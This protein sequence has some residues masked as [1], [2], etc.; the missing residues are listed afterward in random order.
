[1]STSHLVWARLGSDVGKKIY[2]QLKASLK[3]IH[4]SINEY[5]DNQTTFSPELYLG[6]NIDNTTRLTLENNIG[7]LV[8]NNALRSELEQKISNYEILRGNVD[9]KNYIYY[10][11]VLTLSKNFNII[12]MSASVGSMIYSHSVQDV[13]Y[14][15]GDKLV[16]T[17]K[18]GDRYV[19]SKAEIAM[20]GYL[21]NRSLQIM[22]TLSYLAM[23]TNDDFRKSINNW[24]H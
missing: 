10:N 16:H 1:M 2:A 22:G 6:Y 5:R 13:Y 8:P 21:L 19:Q 12:N 7:Y 24:T 4:T 15:E 3:F 23:N 18:K 17:F 14:G 11:P 20:T 9:L